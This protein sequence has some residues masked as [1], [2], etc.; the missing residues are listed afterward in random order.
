MIC[1]YGVVSGTVQ[2]VGFRA[3][4]QGKA[5]AAGLHGFAR[6]LRDGPVEVML[7]GDAAAVATVE[8]EVAKGPPASKVRDVVWEERP[9]MDMEGFE[10]S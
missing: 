6:N 5:M 7:C 9:Y 10:R 8:A 3:Y 4:V 1:R 2:G